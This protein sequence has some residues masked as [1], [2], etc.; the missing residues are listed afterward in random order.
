[1]SGRKGVAKN[2]ST[3]VRPTT[4]AVPVE[5]TVLSGRRGGNHSFCCRL[6]R[7][8]RALEDVIGTGNAYPPGSSRPVSSTFSIS[9]RLTACRICHKQGYAF[10]LWRETRGRHPGRRVSKHSHRVNRQPTGPPCFLYITSSRLDGSRDEARR[11][12]SGTSPPCG[13]G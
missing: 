1:M 8:R 13:R 10:D 3:G 11:R 7:N 9:S 5:N 6:V 2:R 12:S 4:M